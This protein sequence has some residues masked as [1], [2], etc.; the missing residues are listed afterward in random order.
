M[1]RV[2]L[3]QSEQRRLCSS[4]S[5]CDVPISEG[6]VNLAWP[7]IM[8]TVNEDPYGFFEGGGWNFLTGSGDDSGASES[9]EGS[10]FG[11]DSEGFDDEDEDDEDSE[12]DC[13]LLK[14]G[15]EIAL[16][17]VVNDDDDSGS[18]AGD[19]DDSG[20]DWDEME[21]K[22]KRGACVSHVKSKANGDQRTRIAQRGEARIQMMGGRRRRADV[23]DTA[24]GLLSTHTLISAQCPPPTCSHDARCA[25]SCAQRYATSS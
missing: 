1:V 18:D 23:A 4:Y 6:P 2:S 5:S 12:S 24:H 10:E 21:A 20:E 22:A 3:Q 16:I 15:A 8:K 19:D 17:V 11:E 7:A 25:C 14:L 13:M 9:E